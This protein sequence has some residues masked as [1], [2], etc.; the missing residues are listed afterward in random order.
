[1]QASDIPPKQ[2]KS[3]LCSKVAHHLGV[4]KVHVFRKK[5]CY[6]VL[7][8]TVAFLASHPSGREHQMCEG[9]TID[10][11]DPLGILPFFLSL[12]SMEMAND[13]WF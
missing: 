1:M 3:Q 11:V 7:Q 12:M 13:F 6:K 10:I 4:T 2:T 5:E 8:C 9:T